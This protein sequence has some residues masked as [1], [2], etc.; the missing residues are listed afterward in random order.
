V[1]M[2]DLI[3][4]LQVLAGSDT[5]VSIAGECQMD[6]IIDMSDAIMLLKEITFDMF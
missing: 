5:A 6:G 4:M 3:L 2:T 1:D